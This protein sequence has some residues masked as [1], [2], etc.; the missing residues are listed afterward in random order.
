MRVSLDVLLQ[1]Y[2]SEIRL[3]DGN[4]PLAIFALGVLGLHTTV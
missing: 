3:L 2:Y 4:S 1:P